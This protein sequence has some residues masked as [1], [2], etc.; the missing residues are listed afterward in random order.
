M[1]GNRCTSKVGDIINNKTILKLP[2]ENNGKYL[3]ECSCGNIYNCKLFQLKL[4]EKCYKCQ[5][6][7]YKGLKID[8]HQILDKIINKYQIRCICGNIFLRAQRHYNE[9]G[10]FKGC[11]CS[12][13]NKHLEEAKKKIGMKFGK[14]KVISVKSQDRHNILICKCK[15]G[16]IIEFINGHECKRNSCGCLKKE[17][18]VKGEKKGNARLKNI[19]IESLRNLFSSKMYTRQELCEMFDITDNYLSRI[20]TRSIWKSVV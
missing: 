9:D 13:K 6:G 4:T 11:G 1:P 19:E 10:S 3:A 7:I 14:L 18:A 17:N 2:C 16:N 15:C 5:G 20:I 8:G 12:V